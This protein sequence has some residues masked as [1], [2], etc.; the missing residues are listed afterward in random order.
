MILRVE[1]HIIIYVGEHV[2]VVVAAL[3][4]VWRHICLRELERSVEC[5]DPVT[6]LNFGSLDRG[7]V[8]FLRHH[9]LYFYRMVDG[10]DHGVIFLRSFG[11]HR[12]EVGDGSGAVDIHALKH[13]AAAAVDSRGIF[14]PAHGRV[15]RIV[16]GE[17]V[18]GSGIGHIVGVE[19]CGQEKRA[20]QRRHRHQSVRFGI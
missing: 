13:C 3:I 14:N 17:Y 7:H 9:F 10:V 11:K 15:S 1:F 19:H 5:L 12:K 2:Q 16:G 4:P 18:D 6:F 8:D 20:R